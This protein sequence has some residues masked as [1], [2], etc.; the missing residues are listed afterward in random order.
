MALNIFVFEKFRNAF[1]QKCFLLI[2]EAYQTSLTKKIIQLDWNENDISH[3]LYE[4]I[5]NN[6]LRLRW[7]ISMSKEFSLSKNIIKEKGFADHSPRIDFR[8]SHIFARQEFK[9]YCESKRL[10]ENDSGLKRDYIKEGIDR[11]VS[12]KYP[13][14][15]MLGYLL[16]GEVDG[17]INGINTL[18]EK[19]KRRNEILKLKNNKLL[20]TY[21]ESNH[22]N[23][24]ILKHLI[25]D[26][27]I[28]SN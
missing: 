17:T 7:N 10:K 15:C 4:K 3:E 2:I 19:D 6:R 1:E 9:Y 12:Y 23:I 11:F 22:P 13:L 25:F 26:F 8:M 16:E 28:F 5:D 27:T 18:L 21:Y 24:G 20:K 14:G